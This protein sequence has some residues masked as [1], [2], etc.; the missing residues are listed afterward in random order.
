MS[1]G[2]IIW[3]SLLFLV[4]FMF[5][6]LIPID[7]IDGS[8]LFFNFLCG[9]LVFVCVF[10][11]L[12]DFESSYELLNM[13]DPEV[14]ASEPASRKYAAIAILPG[15][16]TVFALIFYQGD[17]KDEELSKNGVVVKGRVTGGQ[18][19]TTSRRGNR[20]T[21]YTLNVYYLDSLKKEHYLEDD[22]NSSDFNDV[23]EGAV[24]DV[25]YSKKYPSLAKAI[26][27][28]EELSK[29]KKIPQEMIVIGHLLPMLENKIKDDSI[30]VYL[31]SISYEWYST[32][33]KGTYANDKKNVAIQL[34]ADR[35]QIAYVQKV[36]LF[37]VREDEFA[38]SLEANGFRKQASNI[39][40]KEQVLYLSDKY[41]VSSKREQGE[42]SS[43]N[44]LDMNG[45]EIYYIAKVGD[46]N[47]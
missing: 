44:L 6:K 13:N 40:G 1:L 36:N 2:R 16:V 38:K 41:V 26:V 32:G 39:D 20:S 8:M 37:E 11:L 31:N 25:V 45:F 15:I 10:M 33:D 23:Y 7:I 9:V 46:T 18:S 14:K 42:R 24:I 28:V 47:R 34:A 4:L 5:M 22:V 19:K 43:D 27:S 17:R 30:M 3:L 29:Y 12:A 21:S 35:S